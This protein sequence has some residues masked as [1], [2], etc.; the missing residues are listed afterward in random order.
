MIDTFL[1]ILEQTFLHLPLVIG[2]YISISLMKIPDLSLESAYVFGAILGSQVVFVSKGL[3]VLFICFG[4]LGASLLGGAFVGLVSSTI[5]QKGKIPHLLSSI[6]TIGLFHGIDQI[7]IQSYRSLSGYANPLNLFAIIPG[8]PELIMVGIVAC[9]VVLFVFVLL[10]TQLGYS[11]FIF[12]NN[13]QFFKH[14]GISTIYVA[15]AGILISNALAGCSGYLFAQSNGFVE[16]NMG[17]G[18]ILL[19]ITALIMGKVLAMAH[20][21]ISIVIPIIGTLSYFTLQQLLLKIGFTLKYFTAIQAAL[22][23][24]L[25]LVLFQKSGF[26]KKVDHLGV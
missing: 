16:V 22:I 17:F 15:M 9:I 11:F 3:P 26:R 18:K 19:C 8:H 5:T 24:L 10:K 23:L 2:A 13:P 7:F 1:I 4:A 21:P 6:I 20:K 25:L 12:G 14:Y